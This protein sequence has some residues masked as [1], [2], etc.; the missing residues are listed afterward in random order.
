MAENGV[1]IEGLDDVLAKLGKLG[2]E[3]QKVAWD[4]LKRGGMNIIADAQENL[5][6]NGHNGGPI[7]ATGRLS[8]SGRVQERGDGLEV[9]FFSQGSEEGYA[10]IVE[11]GSTK[12]WWV[13]LRYLHAWAMVK[14]SV[15]E[16]DA[17][18]IAKGSQRSIHERGLR[19]HPFFGPAVNGNKSKLLEAVNKA[20]KAKIS[21]YGRKV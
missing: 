18:P 7:N 3:V 20:V 14:F 4:G 12:R 10:A 13:P 19:P 15:N 5:K 6:K 21:K 8:N 17:W 1:H 2:P 9:G 11:F 16:K